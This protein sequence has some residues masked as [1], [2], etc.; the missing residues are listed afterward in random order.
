MN[1][2]TTPKIYSQ[3]TELQC[4]DP[5]KPLDDLAKSAT[6]AM[7]LGAKELFHTNFLAFILESDDPSLETLQDAIRNVL[8][9]PWMQGEEHFCLIW[10]EKYNFDLIIIPIAMSKARLAKRTAG[11]DDMSAESTTADDDEDLAGLVLTKRAVVVE[12]KLKSIPSAAQLDGYSTRLGTG[13]SLE[14]PDAYTS[15]RPTNGARPAIK[16]NGA[17]CLLLS[18]RDVVPRVQAW[19]WVGWT[20]IY[21]AFCSSL[22]KPSTLSTILADYRDSLGNLLQVLAWIECLTDREFLQPQSKV[23]FGC[24][25]AAMNARRLRDRRLHDLAGKYCF[26]LIESN[27]RYQIVNAFP[28]SFEGCHKTWTLNTYSGFSNM[29]PLVAFEWKCV[30]ARKTGRAKE[31]AIFIGIQIQ[32]TSYRHFVA[33]TP[34]MK[35]LEKICSSPA[36]WDDFL[37][38]VSVGAKCRAAAAIFLKK[39][40]GLEVKDQ[41]IQKTMLPTKT[42][43]FTSEVMPRKLIGRTTNLKAFNVNHF[44]YSD[45]DCGDWNSSELRENIF[46]SLCLAKEVID[47]CAFA[48]LEADLLAS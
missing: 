2:A 23:Q 35:S 41:N 7:S 43:S 40:E 12:A 33:V 1:D 31:K 11:S 21:S 8:H 22:P 37:N 32:G 13:L 48:P 46:I 14:L 38:P 4:K 42:A 24:L 27:I 39:F 3:L 34:H 20:A 30:V 26:S 6:F 16:I 19:T 5:K 29:T 36:I 17:K 10:R 28:M 9:C 18:P 44:L 15:Q 47:Q 45:V 25:Q